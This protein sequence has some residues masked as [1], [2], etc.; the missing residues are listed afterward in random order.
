VLPHHL[1]YFFRKP[2]SKLF[3]LITVQSFLWPLLLN[4][5]LSFKGPHSHAV[6]FSRSV[7]PG[8]CPKPLSYLSTPGVHYAT[9]SYWI[10]WLTHPAQLSEQYLY[11]HVILPASITNFGIILY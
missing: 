3:Y 6:Q 7:G 9:G 5:T 8:L 2:D 4:L 10:R 1:A 11:Y